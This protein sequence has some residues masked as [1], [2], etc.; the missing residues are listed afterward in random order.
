MGFCVDVERTIL[1]ATF[2]VEINILFATFARGLYKVCG[3]SSEEIWH[4]LKNNFR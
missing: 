4:V 1:F 3:F 2:R